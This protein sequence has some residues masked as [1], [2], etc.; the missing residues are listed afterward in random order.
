MTVFFD[1][2]NWYFATGLIMLIVSVSWFGFQI[3]RR[4]KRSDERQA[5]YED[6]CRKCNRKEAK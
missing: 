4:L 3:G 1:Y 2:F 5:I 6:M